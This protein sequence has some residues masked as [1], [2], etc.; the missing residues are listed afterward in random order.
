MYEGAT[1]L[2]LE[3]YHYFRPW[4]NDSFGEYCKNHRGYIDGY[5]NKRII[6]PPFPVSYVD[7]NGVEMSGYAIGQGFHTCDSLETCMSMFRAELQGLLKGIRNLVIA[8]C[9]IPRGNFYYTGYI[10]HEIF[11]PC[12]AS[13]A[14]KIEKIIFNSKEQ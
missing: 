4:E 1:N 10:G 5:G 11:A 3:T 2:D 14:L 13:T 6:A 8:E 7:D 12:Y 9:V